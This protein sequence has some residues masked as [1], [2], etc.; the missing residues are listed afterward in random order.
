[1]VPVADVLRVEVDR[2]LAG[3][4]GGREVPRSREDEAESA[5]DLRVLRIEFLRPL[6]VRLGG[7]EVAE[8]HV[9]ADKL[10]L[11]ERL[12]REKA[13]GSGVRL[14]GLRGAPQFQPELPLPQKGRNQTGLQAAGILARRQACPVPRVPARA[15][16]GHGSPPGRTTRHWVP[17]PVE[18]AAPGPARAVCPGGTGAS[19][20]GRTTRMR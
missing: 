13:C 8:V 3:M 9:G 4:G 16:S 11:D 7:G 2:L 1:E 6:R 10:Q 17:F 14:H 15:P 5:V 12:V 20:P 18:A 19:D